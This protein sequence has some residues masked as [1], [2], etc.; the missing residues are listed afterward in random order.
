MDELIIQIWNERAIFGVGS[1]LF[2]LA[3]LDQKLRANSRRLPKR[4]NRVCPF[5][6]VWQWF[7]SSAPLLLPSKSILRPL[8]NQPLFS[9]IFYRHLFIHDMGQLGAQTHVC[10]N[11]HLTQPETENY[12][13]NCLP[14]IDASSY[15]YCSIQR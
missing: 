2:Y 14:L 5:S 10:T 9:S 4:P 3:D 6:N 8:I 12:I 15:I 13:F 1:F 11:T 7:S